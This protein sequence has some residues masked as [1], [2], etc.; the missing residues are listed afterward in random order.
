MPRS[1]PPADLAAQLTADPTALLRLVDG[2]ATAYREHHAV[3]EAQRTARRQIEADERVA[4]A[5]IE[6]RRAVLLEHLTRSF[7]ERAH[8]FTALFT[9]LD[10]ALEQRDPQALA[11]LTEAIT[12]L[13]KTSPLK[14]LA[15]VDATRRAVKGPGKTWEV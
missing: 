13:A 2:M 10:A 8:T 4:L 12:E 9:R 11:A 1:K 6:A 5:E 7:D 14:E 15:S 3:R